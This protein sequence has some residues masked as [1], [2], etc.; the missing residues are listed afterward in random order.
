[1]AGFDRPDFPYALKVALIDRYRTFRGEWETEPECGVR[2]HRFSL[3][4]VD[5]RRIGELARIE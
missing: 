2:D 1:M 5:V 3:G 4:A